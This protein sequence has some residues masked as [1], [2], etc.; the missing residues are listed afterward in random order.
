MPP[1]SD[2]TFLSHL[3]HADP[4]RFFC[5]L[6]APN[7]KR[8]LLAILYLFNNELA[9]AREVASEP[10]LARIRLQW[11]REVVEGA[12]KKHDIATPLR[13]AIEAGTLEADDLAALIDAREMEADE[14]IVDF[15]TFCTYARGTGGRLARIAGKILG[16]DLPV[17]EDLGTGYAIAGILRAAPYLAKQNRS[18]LP[19]DG[20]AP[21]M[22]A[23]HA[24]RLLGGQPPR[25]TLAAAL[26]AV[27]ARRDLARPHDRNVWD[28]VAVLRTALMGRV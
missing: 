17:L 26:P 9:R 2:P 27:L 6:F 22:L 21:D 24:R 28:R 16:A 15:P 25:I 8:E 10:M 23:A 14:E 19:A 1:S 3:R 12:R 13:D 7:C 4:D 11:W 20:T 18:L 5:T